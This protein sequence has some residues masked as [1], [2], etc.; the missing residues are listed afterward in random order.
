MKTLALAVVL[1]LAIGVHAEPDATATLQSGSAAEIGQTSTRTV[2]SRIPALMEQ[3]RQQIQELLAGAGRTS[4]DDL[5]R[6]IEAIKKDTEMRRLELLAEE[7]RLSGR[8]EEADRADAE[9]ARLEAG[10]VTRTH[11][12]VLSLEQKRAIGGTDQPLARPYQPNASS[13]ATEGGVR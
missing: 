10:D 3:S 13:S 7:C 9:R 8:I 11:A 12:E 5:Q 1:G 4:G 2:E 6:R